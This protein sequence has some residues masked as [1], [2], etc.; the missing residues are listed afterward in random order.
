M[1]SAIK[2]RL[3]FKDG[4]P[5]KL[6]KHI[7]DKYGFVYDERV[8]EKHVILKKP[9]AFIMGHPPARGTMI[10]TVG[11]A[12]DKVATFLAPTQQQPSLPLVT[13]DQL[14]ANDKIELGRKCMAIKANFHDPETSAAM[15]RFRIGEMARPLN[16]E[17]KNFCQEWVDRN[18]DAL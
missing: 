8:F 16:R 4:L 14:T 13:S 9:A 5:W 6:Q 7:T 17:Q 10:P 12:A 18:V 3:K 1:S 11:S 15:I 2:A